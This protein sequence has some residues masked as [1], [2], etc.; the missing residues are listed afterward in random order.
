MSGKTEVLKTLIRRRDEIISKK[1]TKIT[2][3]HGIDDADYLSFAQ[4]YP[5]VNFS[6]TYDENLIFPDSLII[7]DDMH[8]QLNGTL[9]ESVTNLVTRT[10]HHKRVSVCIVL[11]SI[12][13]VPK[14]RLSLL[15]ADYL[16]WFSSLFVI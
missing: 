2:Y 12:F 1:I 5:I 9:N 4:Q 6:S 13:G 11:H 3:F 14:M 7:L 8:L 10:C 15:S 16:V